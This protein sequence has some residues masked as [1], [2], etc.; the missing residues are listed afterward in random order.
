MCGGEVRRED[1]G[2]RSRRMEWPTYP[3]VELQC[4]CYCARYNHRQLHTWLHPCAMPPVQGYGLGRRE[5][6]GPG[7]PATDTSRVTLPTQPGGAVGVGTALSGT[8]GSGS[9]PVATAE[10]GVGPVKY[11]AAG[12]SGGTGRVFVPPRATAPDEVRQCPR[13]SVSCWVTSLLQL[14][15]GSVTVPCINVRPCS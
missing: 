13:I 11:K 4:A 3:E 6:S 15:G 8:G 5:G 14:L 1:K 10:G 12:E 9:G 7:A 2:F